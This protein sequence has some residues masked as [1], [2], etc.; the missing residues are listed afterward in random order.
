M[1][2][3]YLTA[4]ALVQNTYSCLRHNPI[5]IIDDHHVFVYKYT[6]PIVTTCLYTSALLSAELGSR[7]HP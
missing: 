1:F 6:R 7:L 4:L 3:L 2:P 5:T